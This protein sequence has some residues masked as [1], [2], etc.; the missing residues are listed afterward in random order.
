M[1]I[2]LSK[3][4]WEFVDELLFMNWRLPAVVFVRDSTSCRLFEALDAVETRKTALGIDFSSSACA[5][6]AGFGALDKV[7]RP[8][9]VIE[10]FWDGDDGG[11]FIILAAIVEKPSAQH[12]RY[13]QYGLCD[14]RGY[15]RQVEQAQAL[16][17]ELAAVAG[18][19]YYLTSIEEDDEKRWWDTETT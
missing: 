11:W 15:P 19:T 7:P 4:Q 18:T 17:E 6:V 5:R 10:G 8:I 14:I 13:T 2:E 1:P 12:P 9:R 3:D 16:G